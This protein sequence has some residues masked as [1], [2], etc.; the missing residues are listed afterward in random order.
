MESRRPDALFRDPVAE[1]IV[2]SIDWD[3]TAFEADWITHVGVAVRTEI[4]DEATRSFLARNPGALVVNLGAGLC[5]RFFRVDDDAV[6]WIDVDLPDVIE[7]KHRVLGE[8]DRYRLVPMSLLD[9]RWM[10]EIGW[11]MAR[12]ALVIA[13][14]VLQYLPHDDVR[15]LLRE[16]VLRHGMVEV[17]FDVVSPFG[18]LLSRWQPSLARLGVRA[19]WG[20]NDATEVASW[21]QGADVVAEWTYDR[22]LSRWRWVELVHRIPAVRRLMRVVHLR[23]VNDVQGRPPLGGPSRPQ[24]PGARNSSFTK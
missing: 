11:R 9:R 24:G 18:A 23:A 22:H 7:L 2:D 19:A 12:P 10:E 21:A 16:I 6:E 5:T 13:E 1:E 14:G 17:L 3:S 4:L 20:V 8:R 15:S